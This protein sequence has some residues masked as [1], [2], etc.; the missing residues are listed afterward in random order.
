MTFTVAALLLIASSPAGAAGEPVPPFE[1]ETWRIDITHSD[2]Y[3]LNVRYMVF[4]PGWSYSGDGFS[5]AHVTSH[6]GCGDSYAPMLLNTAYAAEGEHEVI[7]YFGGLC[8]HDGD[9]GEETKYDRYPNGTQISVDATLEHFLPGEDTP[10]ETIPR[11]GTVVVS[12]DG[13]QPVWLWSIPVT[14]AAPGAE[15][16][17]TTSSAS[18][19]T[20][21]ED[22]AAGASE[23]EESDIEA[24]DAAEGES[25]EADGGGGPIT[26][27]V[28]LAGVLLLLLLGLITLAQI[29]RKPKGIPPPGTDTSRP[30]SPPTPVDPGSE[31]PEAAAE[32]HLTGAFL[33][34]ASGEIGALAP[35]SPPTGT[36]GPGRTWVWVSHPLDVDYY[37]GGAMY[38]EPVEDKLQPGRWYQA[39]PRDSYDSCTVWSEDGEHM[40]GDKVSDVRSA[41]DQ[42]T[43]PGT[44]S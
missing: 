8:T 33:D 32:Q 41:P 15:A 36:L 39:G 11:G 35:S 27:G 25:S 44:R 38:G 2:E 3:W 23:G 31:A 4:P 20:G 37:D 7:V 16:I 29:T 19:T 10:V 30:D 43:P 42:T 18:T 6:S 1:D 9:D 14:G 13:S 26:L 5:G 34:M 24:A 21:A 12:T 40:L 28:L 17:E 22:E